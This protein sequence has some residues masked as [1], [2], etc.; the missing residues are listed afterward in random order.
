MKRTEQSV[1]AFDLYP[2]VKPDARL[3]D[4]KQ[5]CKILRQDLLI[6]VRALEK[7]NPGVQRPAVSPDENFD[8]VD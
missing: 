3:F 6:V 2:A 7:L 1:Y 4:C 8:A 5:R